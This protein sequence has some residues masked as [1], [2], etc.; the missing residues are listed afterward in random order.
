MITKKFTAA[1]S[2]HACH[3]TPPNTYLCC[4]FWNITRLPTADILSLFLVQRLLL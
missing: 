1:T 2:A 3:D 4:C